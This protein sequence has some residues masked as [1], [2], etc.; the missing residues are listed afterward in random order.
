MAVGFR[1]GRGSSERRA[2]RAVPIGLT[3]KEEVFGHQKE[4]PKG[5]PWQDANLSYTGST[6]ILCAAQGY[7]HNAVFICG[8]AA[9]NGNA[10]HHKAD[11]KS[12]CWSELLGSFASCL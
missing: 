9:D 11:L 6:V 12:I 3:G 10:P 1:K 2:L 8:R 4:P 5:R 7:L